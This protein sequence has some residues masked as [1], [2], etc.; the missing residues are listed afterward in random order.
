MMDAYTL[1]QTISSVST[2]EEFDQQ[3]Q[4]ADIPEA[5]FHLIKLGVECLGDEIDF[6]FAHPQLG[7][8]GRITG[9]GLAMVLHNACKFIK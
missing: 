8:K 5:L 9:E 7:L 4:E 3:L 6:S 2:D 1:I